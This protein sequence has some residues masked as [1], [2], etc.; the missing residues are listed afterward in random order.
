MHVMF[1][2]AGVVIVQTVIIYRRFHEL[3]GNRISGRI[4]AEDKSQVQGRE[5]PIYLT[6]RY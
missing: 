1:E 5:V 6:I 2:T 4:S 3:Q